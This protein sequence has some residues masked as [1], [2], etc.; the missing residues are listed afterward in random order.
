MRE[1]STGVRIM[2]DND[3][4]HYIV[5]VGLEEEFEKW[6]WYSENNKKS[7]KLRDFGLDRIDRIEDIIIYI[8]E[9]KN[10]T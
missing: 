8:W 9:D 10:Q 1:N 7:K 4:H 3:N 2:S 6:V 5:P